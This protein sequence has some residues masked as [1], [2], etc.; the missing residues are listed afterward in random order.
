M[1]TFLSVWCNGS[2]AV[3]NRVEWD[4]IIKNN[5]TQLEPHIGNDMSAGDDIGESLTAN[6]EGTQ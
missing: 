5:F 3:F 2:T 1:T 4:A 6:A